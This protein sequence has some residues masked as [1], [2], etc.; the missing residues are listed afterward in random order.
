MGYVK[1]AL[2]FLKELFG[3]LNRRHDKA[4][5]P[6]QLAKDAQAK[7]DSAV[8]KGDADAVNTLLADELNR[9]QAKG[10]DSVSGQKS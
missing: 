2:E 9:L 6:E 3:F 7:I 10:G 1:A 8:A 5:T 4:N